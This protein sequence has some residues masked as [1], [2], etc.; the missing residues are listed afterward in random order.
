[1]LKHDKLCFDRPFSPREEVLFEGHGENI[2]PFILIPASL[3]ISATVYPA[4]DQ[5]PSS[6]SCLHITEHLQR[7]NV[8]TSTIAYGSTTYK[9][10]LHSHTM[11]SVFQHSLLYVCTACSDMLNNRG[12]F[13][14]ISFDKISHLG[15]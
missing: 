2:Y 3:E 13:T 14:F 8:H 10:M 7:L 12:I 5:R 11:S 1:M 4:L 9:R 15:V 6:P